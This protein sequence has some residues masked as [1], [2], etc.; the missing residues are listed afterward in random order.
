VDGA[1]GHFVLDEASPA[2]LI[3][4]GIG[5]TPLKGM[6]EYAADRQLPVDLRLVYSNRTEEEIAYRSELDGLARLN[7]RFTVYHSL[8]R[9]RNDSTWLGRRGRIDKALLGEASQGLS[10]PIYYLCGAPGLVQDTHRSLREL[11]ISPDRIR[12]EVFRGYGLR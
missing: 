3:A 9:E 1:Y 7:S 4:G 6:A 5:I 8:T 12:F 2:V 11:G 10:D